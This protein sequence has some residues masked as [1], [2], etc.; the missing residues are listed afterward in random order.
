M[1]IAY[2]NL[3]LVIMAGSVNAQNSIRGII[4]DAHTQ[5]GLPHANIYIE[6]TYIG[7]GSNESGYYSL[8]IAQ[9]PSVIIVSHNGYETCVTIIEKYGENTT[10]I[11]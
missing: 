6:N 9:I 1:K 7:T 10:N 3:L 2:M 4:L 11:A 5:E 8:E